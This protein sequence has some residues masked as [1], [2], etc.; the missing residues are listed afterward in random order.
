MK[1]VLDRP[2]FTMLSEL[3]ENI[4]EHSNT[5]LDGFA[6][7]QYYGGKRNEVFIAVSD[8]GEGPM[9]RLRPVLPEYYPDLVNA[10]ESELLVAMFTQGVSRFGKK[11][12]SGLKSAGHHA[13]K[14]NS[15]LDVRIPTTYVQLR[16][17]QDGRYKA[18]GYV[19]SDL[20][21]VWGTHVS[22]N[23]KLDALA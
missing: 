15:A 19:S 6:V 1:R 17:A 2:V 14:F 16:P 20:P 9:A 8:S 7:S 3:I 13:L 10:T 4:Y 18:K 5:E 21:V 23:F 22:F 12:G 11:K